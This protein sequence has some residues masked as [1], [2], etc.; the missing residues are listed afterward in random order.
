MLLYLVVSALF[1]LAVSAL[2]IEAILK[3]FGSGRRLKAEAPLRSMVEIRQLQQTQVSTRVEEEKTK[4][5]P[6]RK[7]VSSSTI[8]RKEDTQEQ[9]LTTRKKQQEELE[10]QI[11][12]LKNA[13][14]EATHNMLASSRNRSEPKYS[15]ETRTTYYSSSS[16][17]SIDYR[18]ETL[19]SWTS[20]K[21]IEERQIREEQDEE[22]QRALEEDQLR[23]RLALEEEIKRNQE[24]ER[25]ELRRKERHERY[26]ALPSEP[27]SKASD[28]T[29]LRFR[30]PD[31]EIVDR[32]FYQS[33]LL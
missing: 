21:L 24:T 20:Q 9:L 6:K 33:D 5:L 1:L 2:L 4:S 26:L 19:E 23:E 31:G 3:C 22:F 29:H 17:S 13:L 7:Q 25:K 18:T 8:E 12:A 16:S 30:L 27:D 14:Q 11:S 28:I 15:E 10:Q 32:R